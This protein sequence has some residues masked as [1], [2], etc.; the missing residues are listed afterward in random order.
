MGLVL[1]RGT[2]PEWLHTGAIGPGLE[3]VL[4][5]E[6]LRKEVEVGRQL[7]S[8]SIAVSSYGNTILCQLRRQLNLLSKF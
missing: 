2:L 5:K 7:E 6:L 1:D 4:F 3:G 8:A